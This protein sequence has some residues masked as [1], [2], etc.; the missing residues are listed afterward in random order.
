MR[1]AKATWTRCPHRPFLGGIPGARLVAASLIVGLATVSIGAT[2]TGVGPAFAGIAAKHVPSSWTATELLVPANASTTMYS[3]SIAFVLCRRGKPCVATGGYVDTSGDGQGLIE[4]MS[5]GTSTPLEAPLPENAATTNQHADVTGLSCPAWDSC[6][7]VGR[8]DDTTGTQQGLIETLSGGEWIATEALQPANA[9]TTQDSAALYRITCRAVGLCI[10]TGTY[11]DTGGNVRGF[12]ETL[13]GGTW[14]TTE[15]PLPANASTT[16]YSGLD[17]VVCPAAGSCV[18]L[19]SYA[20][21]ITN[22]QGFFETQSGGTWTPTEAPLPANDAVEKEG[23][24]NVVTCPET[25]SCVAAGFYTDTSG[26][27]QGLIETRSR[28]TWTASEAPTLANASGIS[29][30][31]VACSSAASCVAVGSFSD[32][33][34]NFSGLIETR[35]HGTWTPSAAPLPANVALDPQA[36][37]GAISCAGKRSCVAVGDY[38]DTG[39]TLQGLIEMSSGGTWTTSEAPLP[40]NAAANPKA[41]FLNVQCTN[42]D[43]CL[44]TGFY[45]DT[46][47]KQHDLIE[48]LTRATH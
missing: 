9:S 37:L 45:V 34:G 13:S 32:T 16:Q 43:S 48:T 38:H 26:V 20:D 28:G 19:G 35:S 7:G 21:S 25:G 12:F 22:N 15:A 44:A 42:A 5:R 10:A 40:T 27:G 29:L 30:V 3:P 41:S 46:S 39:G 2:G 6:T 31:S 1:R 36:G 47:G 4:T 14:T 8:Y 24:I 17:A 23:A 33:T 18:A 11:I